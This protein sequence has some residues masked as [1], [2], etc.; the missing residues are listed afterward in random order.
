M[1]TGKID[2]V[3]I[4]KNMMLAYL[5]HLNIQWN[6]PRCPSPW[7]ALHLS[8]W[9]FN[10]WSRQVWDN[11]CLTAVLWRIPCVFH[12]FSFFSIS[13]YM[14]ATKIK[15]LHSTACILSDSMSLLSKFVPYGDRNFKDRCGIKLKIIKK[16]NPV[17][18]GDHVPSTHVPPHV[19]PFLTPEFQEAHPITKVDP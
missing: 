1:M 13:G 4:L 5:G 3:L 7:H 16:T 17:N 6:W 14:P 18:I 10:V 8:C 9:V 2:D 19:S 11:Q 12:F 15:S